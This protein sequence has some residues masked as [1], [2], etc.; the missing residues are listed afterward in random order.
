ML[1]YVSLSFLILLTHAFLKLFH[2]N[3]FVLP[4]RWRD[5]RFDMLSPRV[6]YR[7]AKNKYDGRNTASAFIMSALHGK[8][9]DRLCSQGHDVTEKSDTKNGCRNTANGRG[10]H[11]RYRRCD[12]DR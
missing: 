9:D 10:N 8:I 2:R 5:D 1:L 6:I 3:L 4:L 12:L 7:P 11:V